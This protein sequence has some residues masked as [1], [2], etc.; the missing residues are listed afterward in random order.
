MRKNIGIIILGIML[1]LNAPAQHDHHNTHANSATVKA[2]PGQ[3]FVADLD[4]RT[5]ME[6]ILN[7]MQSL[8]S[9]KDLDQTKVKQAGNDVEKT[10]QDIFK[11]C[12]LEPAADNAIHP[13]LAEILGGANLL[14]KGD[15]KK[16]TQKVHQALLKY[17]ELFDHKDWKHKK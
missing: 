14:K 8:H 17:E 4:L 6:S 16:G 3:R 12:K 1:G 10:V 15:Q 2:N 5:R 13:V 11:N 7:T 9:K